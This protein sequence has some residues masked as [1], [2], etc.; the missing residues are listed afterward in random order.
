MRWLLK[1][2]VVIYL[3]YYVFWAAQLTSGAQLTSELRY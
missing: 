3:F 1:Y 2:H